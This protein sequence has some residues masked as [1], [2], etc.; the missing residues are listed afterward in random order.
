MR[1]RSFPILAFLGFSL[2]SGAVAAQTWP[3]VIDLNADG[4]PERIN[5]DGETHKLTINDVDVTPESEVYEIVVQDLV[6][7]DSFVE[8]AATTESM[9]DSYAIQFLRWNGTGLVA[10]PEIWSFNTHDVRGDGTVVTY[11]WMGFWQAPKLYR[12]SADG[13][14]LEAVAQEYLA[15]GQDYNLL[16]PLEVFADQGLTQSLV[17]IQPGQVVHFMASSPDQSRFMIRTPQ[18]FVG[19]ISVETVSSTSF[20]DFVWAG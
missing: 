4:T 8:L 12:L 6:R 11:E 7:G 13:S 10:L 9:D 16:S 19:W 18:G 3:M 14:A 20:Q 15:I 5:W 2:F 1:R 17:T